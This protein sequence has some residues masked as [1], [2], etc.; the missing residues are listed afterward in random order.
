MIDLDEQSLENQLEEIRQ[1]NGEGYIDAICTLCDNAG[2]E[3]SFVAKHLSQPLR[4]KIRAEG[5]DMNLL[6]KSPQLPV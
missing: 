2:V 5:E 3:P 1:R 6:K 4:E